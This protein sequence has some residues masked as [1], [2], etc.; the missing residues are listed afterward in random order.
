MTEDDFR[1]IADMMFHAI[2]EAYDNEDDRNGAIAWTSR[3]ILVMHLNEFPMYDKRFCELLHI[4]AN[5][6]QLL[7]EAS[8]K[9]K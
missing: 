4:L 7:I 9:A 5:T 6:L 2:D 1:P 8:K 3:L